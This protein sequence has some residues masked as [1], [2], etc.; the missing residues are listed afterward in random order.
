M[1][2]VEEVLEGYTGG[3]VPVFGERPD[4]EIFERLCPEQRR[5]HQAQV[6]EELLKETRVP[7]RLNPAQSPVP[8]V[9]PRENIEIIPAR[10]PLDDGFPFEQVTK[11]PEFTVTEPVP[12]FEETMMTAE[13]PGEEEPT[14]TA[15]PLVIVSDEEEAEIFEGLTPRQETYVPGYEAPEAPLVPG[16]SEGPE[17]EL[18]EFYEPSM[19]VTQEYAPEDV[20][21]IS[22]QEPFFEAQEEEL[23]IIPSEPMPLPS[24]E[25]IEL[26]ERTKI[27]PEG[28][29]LVPP[30]LPEFEGLPL[31][32]TPTIEIANLRKKRMARIHMERMSGRSLG[33]PPLPGGYISNREGKKALKVFESAK[34]ILKNAEKDISRPDPTFNQRHEAQRIGPILRKCREE[35]REL[36]GSEG[37]LDNS[38]T[39][40]GDLVNAGDSPFVAP[41]ELVSIDNMGECALRIQA[42]R[43]EERESS[44]IGGGAG[45]LATGLLAFI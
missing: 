24:S 12:E 33:V 28:L 16:P 35:V 34:G 17:G 20:V 19:E 29:R 13:I 23:E 41:E 7:I 1:R 31:E 4:N 43:K 45:I 30:T 22:V 8:F 3:L 39:E 37:N 10:C 15:E 25:P 27:P 44:M 42:I 5:D 14:P 11:E 40:I 38:M 9:K 6:R 26:E 32:E 21:P 18:Q 36:M 2:Y